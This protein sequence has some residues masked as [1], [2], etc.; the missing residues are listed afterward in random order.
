MTKTKKE[1][2]RPLSIKSPESLDYDYINN[3]D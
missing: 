3:K 1:H 2:T